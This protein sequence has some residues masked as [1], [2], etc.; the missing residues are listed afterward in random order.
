MPVV[1]SSGSPTALIPEPEF[2]EEPTSKFVELDDDISRLAR[3]RTR[4]GVSSYMKSA[5]TSKRS[6]NPSFNWCDVDIDTSDGDIRT[7]SMRTQLKNVLKSK[8]AAESDHCF[9]SAFNDNIPD[10]SRRHKVENL[11][12][13][14]VKLARFDSKSFSDALATDDELMDDCDWLIDDDVSQYSQPIKKQKRG[15]SQWKRKNV[16]LNDRDDSDAET[17]QSAFVVDKTSQAKCMKQQTTAFRL[18]VKINDQ[19]FMMVVPGR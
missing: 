16:L 18:R 13:F 8:K 19:A 7:F 3:N 12:S 2:N 1:K 14:R 11:D 6:L 5:A 9:V 4:I 10:I 17:N 15:S